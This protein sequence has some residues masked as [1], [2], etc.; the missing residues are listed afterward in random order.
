MILRGPPK[1]RNKKRPRGEKNFPPAGALP[2]K[3]RY[4]IIG[5]KICNRPVSS[6]LKKPGRVFT[7]LR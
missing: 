2:D 4:H 7:Y 3:K 6:L 1:F 5:A